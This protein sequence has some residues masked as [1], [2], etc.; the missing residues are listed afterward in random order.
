MRNRNKRRLRK[1]R[2]QRRKRSIYIKAIADN[3]V[4]ER[5]AQ[6]IESK[7]KAL[8][9]R[10]HDLTI[11]LAERTKKYETMNT[12]PG[13]PPRPY[14]SWYEMFL[15]SRYWVVQGPVFDTVRITPGLAYANHEDDSCGTA[16]AVLDVPVH[17]MLWGLIN[18]LHGAVLMP[19]GY[20]AICEYYAQN[21]INMHE[22]GPHEFGCTIEGVFFNFSHLFSLARTRSRYERR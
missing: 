22:H 6:A 11:R 19:S 17:K 7:N 15:Q 13:P 3:K 9:E 20:N 8:T 14:T 16:Q 10:N 12:N 2:E 18:E 4:W 1:Q 21:G 5:F